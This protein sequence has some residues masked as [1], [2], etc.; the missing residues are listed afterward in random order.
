[1]N[2]IPTQTSAAE[3]KAQI[4]KLCREYASLEHCSHRPGTDPQRNLQSEF[5]PGKTAIPYAGRVFTGEEV[6]AA[7][8]A[9]LDFWLTLGPE[10]EAFE[11][12]LARFLK[13][14]C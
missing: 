11:E 4:L 13:V 9:T 3:L 6:E 7:V 1:M 10:G 12:E 2:P 8:S 14:Q 5:I